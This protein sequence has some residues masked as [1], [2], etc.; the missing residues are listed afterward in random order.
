[1]TQE[2]ILFQHIMN[3]K[4]YRRGMIIAR[5]C[6]TAVLVG[7]VS[8]LCILSVFLACTLAA[9][10]IFLGI[11]SVLVALGN[12]QTYTIYNTRVVIKPRGDGKRK[13]I[14]LDDIC[15]VKV[16]RAYYEKS[17]YTDTVTIIAKDDDGRRKKYR[18]KHIFDVKPTVAFLQEYIAGKGKTEC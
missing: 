1:M 4:A 17:L 10:I 9:A 16:K 13:I 18:L 15:A 12:E 8:A 2:K 6:I 7:A 14:P 3:Y 11:I 5:S